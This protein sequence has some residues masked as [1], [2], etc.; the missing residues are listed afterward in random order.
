M[1]LVS[2]DDDLTE[3]VEEAQAHGIEVVLMAVQAP[4]ASRTR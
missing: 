4:V 2:G 3:A 1:F